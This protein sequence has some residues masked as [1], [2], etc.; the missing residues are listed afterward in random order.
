METKKLGNSDMEI[1]RIGFGAWAIGGGDWQWGWGAQEDQQSIDTI[2]KALEQGINWIDTAPVYGLGHSEEVV[3]KAIKQTSYKPYIFTKCSLVWDEEKNIA[4]N[5]TGESLVQEVEDSLRRLD[6]D[7]I[8]L[9]QIHWPNPD[10]DLEQGWTVLADLQKQG[11]IRTIGVSNFSVS[12]M[13][14]MRKIAPITSNQPPYSLVF[15]EVEDEILPYCQKNGIGTIVYSPMASGLLSG[16]MTM[17]RVENFPANDWRRD[18][19]NFKEP[20]LSRN[21]ALVEV[22]REIGAKHNCTAGEVA[23]AWTLLNPGVT[24]AIVGLR[25]PDQVDGVVHAGE[26]ALDATDVAA[27]Q[28]FL[29]ANP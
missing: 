26:I 6:V 1:T 23:I 2:H 19:D 4:A 3:G 13:D 17:E 11:K 9:M 21:L 16:K 18:S 8:D 14:R 15:P 27:I 20:R 7:V 5:L 10:E 29:T 25:R 28:G 22:L 24:A 12:Q